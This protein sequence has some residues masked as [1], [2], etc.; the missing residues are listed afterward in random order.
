MIGGRTL[1][2]NPF[3]GGVLFPTLLFGLLYAWPCARA[4]PDRRPRPPPRARPPA[5]RPEPHGGRRRAVRV[6][7]DDLRR[8]LGR[9]DLRVARHLLRATGLALPHRSHRRCRSSSSSSFARSHA[10]CETTTGTRSAEPTRGRCGARS[11]A[12]SGSP[13]AVSDPVWTSAR[14]RASRPCPMAEPLPGPVRRR[15]RSCLLAASPANLR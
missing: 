8:R 5:R 13:V 9:P 2:P 1:I 12:A 6:R 11:G 10:S 4:A 15:G 3:F 7:R 14:P